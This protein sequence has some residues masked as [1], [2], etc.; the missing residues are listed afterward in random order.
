MKA[1]VTNVFNPHSTRSGSVSKASW[2]GV[3]TGVHKQL[4]GLTQNHLQSFTTALFSV[5]F[6]NRL[7]NAVFW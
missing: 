1:G 4:A 7:Q 5:D 3:P 2:N 6:Q